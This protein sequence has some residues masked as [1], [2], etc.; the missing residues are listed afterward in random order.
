MKISLGKPN[1]KISMGNRNVKIYLGIG[2]DS[3]RAKIVT[4][5]CLLEFFVCFFKIFSLN[6]FDKFCK[7]YDLIFNTSAL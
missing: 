2:S 7:I 5:L 1:V 3:N 4:C 6:F